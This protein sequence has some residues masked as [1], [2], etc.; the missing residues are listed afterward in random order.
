MWV[1]ESEESL[2]M[3]EDVPVRIY[4]QLKGIHI[5]SKFKHSAPGSFVQQAKRLPKLGAAVESLKHKLVQRTYEDLLVQWKG[6]LT[7]LKVL[8]SLHHDQ[9][10]HEC[11]LG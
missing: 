2:E 6:T 9:G 5:L 7:R 10:A 8:I 11:I 3:S 4:R 1:D